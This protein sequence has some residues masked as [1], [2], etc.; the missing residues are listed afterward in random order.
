LIDAR[1][2]SG[3]NELSLDMLS[4]MTTS[5]D[6][7]ILG[8]SVGFTG[9]NY[10]PRAPL[11]MADG[12]TN[13][14]AAASVQGVRVLVLTCTKLF[15]ASSQSGRTAVNTWVNQ[16]SPYSLTYVCE[17]GG[18]STTASSATVSTSPVT[19]KAP[20]LAIVSTGQGTGSLVLSGGSSSAHYQG[21]TAAS[22]NGPWSPI[23]LVVGN[24]SFS[25]ATTDIARYYR[26]VSQ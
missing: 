11:I 13:T 22:L 23:G 17:Q 18:D 4:L 10:S 26:V 6:G 19:P 15:A 12:T 21:Q 1:A 25:I 24:G 5:S 16:N 8:D 3:L 7:N 14:I 9:D 2:T 20:T